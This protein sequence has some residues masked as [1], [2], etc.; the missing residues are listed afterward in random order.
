MF[1]PPQKKLVDKLKTVDKW[2]KKEPQ[3]AFVSEKPSRPV[4]KIDIIFKNYIKEK[5][6]ENKIKK[7]QPLIDKTISI[8]KN[9]YMLRDRDKHDDKLIL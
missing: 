2:G 1:K 6:K 8:I 3:K 5:V 9:E 4:N 7:Y